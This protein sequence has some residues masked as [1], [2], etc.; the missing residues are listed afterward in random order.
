MEALLGNAKQVKAITPLCI[1]VGAMCARFAL[2][3]PT[4]M[5]ALNIGKSVIMITKLYHLCPLVS[6]VAAAVTNL[7]PEGTQ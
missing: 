4:I 3:A 5:D 7:A 1:G 2:F 6:I